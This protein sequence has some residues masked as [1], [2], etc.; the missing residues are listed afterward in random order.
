MI[1]IS[2]LTFILEAELRY[3]AS[4]TRME[5]GSHRKGKNTSTASLPR[6]ITIRVVQGAV[7]FYSRLI[8]GGFFPSFIIDIPI[9]LSNIPHLPNV[10]VPSCGL[11]K[12]HLPCW[13]CW[14]VLCYI[15]QTIDWK[16]FITPLG[17]ITT[18]SHYGQ[19]I[20]ELLPESF[21][22]TAQAQWS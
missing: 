11:Y 6:I 18:D 19:S 20:S 12:Q 15:D 13:C 22:P 16:V 9:F 4:V 17:V 21:T 2:P 8:G 14:D 10:T 5:R 3:S 7:L 1:F